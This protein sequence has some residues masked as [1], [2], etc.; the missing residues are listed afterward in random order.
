MS[1][2][3]RRLRIPPGWGTTLPLG[4]M[5]VCSTTGEWCVGTIECDVL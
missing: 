2:C 3:H 5:S 1:A 4:S